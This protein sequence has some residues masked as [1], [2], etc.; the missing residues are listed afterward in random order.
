MKRGLSTILPWVDAGQPTIIRG[1][2]GS[3]K[4]SLITAILS[5]LKNNIDLTNVVYA[6]SLFGPEDLISRL[7]R[8]CVRFESSANGRNYRPRSGTKI[9]LVLEDL[10]SATQDLQ[11]LVRNLL[12]E[13]GFH[14]DDLEFASLPVMFLATADATTTLHSRLN[15]LLAAHYLP[16]PT[17]MDTLGIVQVHLEHALKRQKSLNPPEISNLASALHESM[18]AIGSGRDTNFFWTSQDLSVWA[19]TL[20]CYP[21]AR[22]VEEVAQ[23][24]LDSGIQLF[25]AR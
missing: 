9:I 21:D 10:H 18:L 5:S 16:T 7:K 8:S 13:G 25:C 12:Q 11:E 19:R 22:T 20:E 2:P 24:I 23:H 6:S 3:G 15:A 17:T 14:E 1:E 4:S